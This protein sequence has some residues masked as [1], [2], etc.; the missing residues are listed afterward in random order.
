MKGLQIVILSGSGIS[1]PSGLSTF[2][3]PDGIWI[4]Y[5]I[6]EI[7]TPEA[8]ESNPARVL[9]FY[10]QR[11]LQLASVAP[12]PAHLAIAELEQH[13]HVQVIT[14]NVDDLH[15]RAGSSRVIHLHGKLT[16]ARSSRDP[17]IVTDIGYGSILP[18]DCATDGSPLRPNVVWFGES[19][20]HLDESEKLVAEADV[21]LVIGTSL[22]VHPAAGLVHNTSSVAA[23]YYVNIDTDDCPPGFHCVE[24]SADIVLPPLL[25]S[26]SK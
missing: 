25:K 7:A 26:L 19:I 4:K 5:R 8:F 23:K 2:R 13:H 3:D 14:Q 10:N 18:G 21:V 17:S 15:E 12:N 11:R 6:E 22:S 1:A 16:E 20:F 24:G 9:D